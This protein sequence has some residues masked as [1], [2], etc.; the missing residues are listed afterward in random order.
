MSI[1]GL[2]GFINFIVVHLVFFCLINDFFY[3]LSALDDHTEK[4]LCFVCCG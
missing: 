3:Y 2:L 4:D 1:K